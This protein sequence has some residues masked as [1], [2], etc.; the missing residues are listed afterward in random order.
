MTPNRGRGGGA[1]RRPS[2]DFDPEYV[3]YIKSEKWKMKRE[4]YFDRYGRYCRACYTK[5]GHIH[6]HHTSYDRLGR[7][8]F[9]D[10]VPLC[11]ECH[12]GVHALHRKSGRRMTLREATMAY[13]NSK[14]KR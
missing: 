6:L 1:N 8:P 12:K 13:I 9:S 11:T 7:E 2:S 14:R 4:A 3:R 10:L 5:R